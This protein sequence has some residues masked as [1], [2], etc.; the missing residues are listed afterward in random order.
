MVIDPE[1]KANAE[2]D[3]INLVKL[4]EVFGAQEVSQ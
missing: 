3:W 4:M 1:V 2:E